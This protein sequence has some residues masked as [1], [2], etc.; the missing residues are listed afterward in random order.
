MFGFIKKIIIGLTNQ[1][2][3]TRPTLVD[4]NSNETFFI[5]LLLLSVKLQSESD[6]TIDYPYARVYVPKKV[7][8]INIKAFNL[9]PGVNETKCLTQHQSCSCNCRL[10]ESL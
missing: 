2:I 6:N 10:N 7:K 9:I 4:I 8:N 3:Q 1:P 5:H